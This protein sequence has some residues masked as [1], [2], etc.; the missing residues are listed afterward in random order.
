MSSDNGLESTYKVCFKSKYTPGM[1]Q[2]YT[3]KS[4]DMLEEGQVAW[5]VDWISGEPKKVRV[6]K[7]DPTYDTKAEKRFG[8]LAEVFQREPE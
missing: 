3:Y 8:T 6:I 4:K 7:V 2:L 5:I 1:D